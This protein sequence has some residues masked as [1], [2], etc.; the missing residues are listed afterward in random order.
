MLT[1]VFSM[2]QQTPGWIKLAEL[3]TALEDFSQAEA[4]FE[5]GVS[6]SAL[7]MPKLL[8]KVY[9][10][11]EVDEQGDCEKAHSL[12]RCLIGLSGYH[13]AWISYAEFEGSSIPLPHAL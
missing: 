11:F 8:W 9:I 5:L 12:Y 13:K 3:E 6:Q 10:D 1:T 2:T 7:A 4:I